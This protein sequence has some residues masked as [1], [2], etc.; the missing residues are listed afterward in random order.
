MGPNIAHPHKPG[1][2]G[3]NLHNEKGQWVK[4]SNKNVLYL[5]KIVQD[6][7]VN[8]DSKMSHH[9]NSGSALRI[10]IKFCGMKNWGNVIFL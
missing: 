2:T 10:F 5:K 8:L 4:E 6:E 1:S 9:H 7:W 3:T